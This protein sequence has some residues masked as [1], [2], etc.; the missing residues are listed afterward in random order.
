MAPAVAWLAIA[1]ASLAGA[2]DLTAQQ[3]LSVASSVEGVEFLDSRD[4]VRLTLDRPLEGGERVAV[5]F[6]GQDLTALFVRSGTALEYEPTAF[7]LPTGRSEL[8]VFLVGADG[9]WNEIGSYRLEVT[10]PDGG[11]VVSA[12]LPTTAVSYEAPDW[13]RERAGGRGIRWRVQAIDDGGAV[14]AATAWR[15]GTW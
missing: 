13:L 5:L 2:A 11:S 7:P 15:V 10:A 4:P 14:I 9:A 8:A 6:G 3:P 1:F 12:L